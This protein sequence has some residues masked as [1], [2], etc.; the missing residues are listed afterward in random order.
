MVKQPSSNIDELYK[1]AE[2][3]HQE[4]TTLSNKIANGNNGEAMVPGLKGRPRAMEK[5]DADYGG[6]AGRLVDLA[7]SSVVFDTVDDLKKGLTKLEGSVDIVR[8]KDRFAT[9]TAEGYRDVTLNVRMSNGHIAEVQLHLRSVL[10]VKNGPGHKL[11][12]EARS[13]K[14]LASKEGRDLTAAETKRI[15]EIADE[16]KKLYGDA[17]EVGT[18][19]AKRQAD[20][21]PTDETK[22]ILGDLRR[23]AGHQKEKYFPPSDNQVREE[24]LESLS[25]DTRKLAE[26]LSVEDLRKIY[27]TGRIPANFRDLA[28]GEGFLGF[29]R[30]NPEKARVLADAA[31]W[32]SKKDV[33]KWVSE[34][35]LDGASK[36][37]AKRLP[38]VQPNP[39]L[40]GFQDAYRS[41]SDTSKTTPDVVVR[42]T[43]DHDT[44]GA[45]AVDGVGKRS[46]DVV[47]Y[48]VMGPEQLI[49]NGKPLESM[50]GVL[51]F[52]GHGS[53][54]GIG[55]KAGLGNTAEAE[56]VVAKIIEANGSIKHVVLDACDQR[57]LRIIGGSNAQAFQTKVRKLLKKEGYT[58]KVDVLA[59]SKPGSTQGNSIQSIDGSPTNFT[60]ADDGGVAH[61]GGAEALEIVAGAYVVAG[62][63]LAVYVALDD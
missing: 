21:A 19:G 58:G 33:A 60:P 5:A 31:D 3:A 36:R 32:S 30:K 34:L 55:T 13:I 48:E 17:F 61:F 7:R 12:E 38:K 29:A 14:A 9:P 24:F 40:K 10:D 8:K 23:E 1:A 42:A 41:G 44:G 57:N 39:K 50:D 54:Y 43:R 25:G 6:D 4:L 18:T 49:V 35:G 22:G 56:A 2:E 15:A 53:K 26:T 27:P 16:S 59:P 37:F 52:G 51:V 28:M 20:N 47:Q 62:T 45:F 63:G 46:S 11:Y